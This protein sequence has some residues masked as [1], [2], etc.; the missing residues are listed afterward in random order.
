MTHRKLKLKFIVFIICCAGISMF[1]QVQA[2]MV[3]TIEQALDIA[4]ENNPSMRTQK[5]N[6]ER[7]QFL[8][9]AQ[10]ASLRPQFSLSINPF[11]YTQNR[12][13]DN[14]FSEWYTSK[15]LSSNGTFRTE[16]PILFTD[17]TLALTDRFGWQDSESV[18]Q[19]GINNNKAFSNNLSIRYDQP[20]FTYNSQRMA[21][22]RLEYDFENAGIRYALQRLNTE[23]SITN[24][25]YTVYMAMNNLDIS[26]EELNNAKINYDIMKAKVDAALSAREELF[27]AEVNLAS[28]ESSVEQTR[29]RLENAKDQLKQT[30]GMP[31][32]DDITL[33]VPNI[34]VSPTLVDLGEALQQ[35]LSARMELRQREI[36]MAL[37]EFSLIETKAR[38]EFSG[39]LS[40][41]IG[42]TGDDAK[43]GN[44]YDNPTSNPSVSVSFSIPIFDWGQ[45]KARI[46]AS[47]TALTIAQLDYQ[48]QKVDI[49][50]NI[51]QTLRNLANL[52]TQIEIQKKSVENTELTFALNNIRY[53]E[54][55][56]TGL[57][58]S[59]YQ[60]QLSNARTSLIQAR[61]N[62]K[63]ELLNL[64]ILTL[65]DFET[66]QPIVTIRQL[67]KIT[68]R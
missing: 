63:I 60:A 53:A 30:L 18:N 68:M 42:I 24:Q 40:L 41:S 22:D 1:S 43:F 51:R 67:N 17:G 59:Q 16:L 65:Y 66:D 6:L 56:L 5:L 33:E 39:N 45:R 28:A 54:G 35:G 7:T 13:F 11:G 50:L 8:L 55:D 32:G 21:F 61:I 3:L 62:Y 47:K 23:R 2:Q 26:L 52:A 19:N 15:T 4:E 58:I 27:Q 12:S 46:Q 9:D 36:D 31:L 29:V 64:K 34:D 57:Q 44:M 48:D 10:L 14:R 25:F 20:L 49:E 38:D 37:A